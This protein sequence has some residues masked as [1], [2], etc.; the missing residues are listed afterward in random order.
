MG[1]MLSF[2]GAFLLYSPSSRSPRSSCT[3]SSCLLSHRS[4]GCSVRGL[5]H[6]LPLSPKFQA[7]IGDAHSPDVWF[8]KATSLYSSERG[9]LYHPLLCPNMDSLLCCMPPHPH[10]HPGS[11]K[12]PSHGNTQALLGVDW[13]LQRLL[14]ADSPTQSCAPRLKG[15]PGDTWSCTRSCPTM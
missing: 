4:P 1:E 5:R 12:S 11:S 2:P 9:S 6:C 3:L 15:N 14:Q 13:G 10:T 7:G 8:G